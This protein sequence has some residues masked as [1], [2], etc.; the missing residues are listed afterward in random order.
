MEL[1][2]SLISSSYSF[3]FLATNPSA[4]AHPISFCIT[5]NQRE[6][7]DGNET[8][9]DYKRNQFY[10]SGCFWAFFFYVERTPPL[11]MLETFMVSNPQSFSSDY[12]NEDENK[13]DSCL[14]VCGTYLNSFSSLRNIWEHDL[15]HDKDPNRL[16]IGEPGLWAHLYLQQVQKSW[17]FVYFKRL[18]NQ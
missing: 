12:Q 2:L 1:L 4:V 15:N 13:I 14:F 17:V 3:F 7:E 10:F 9:I 11:G 5:K 6:G 18:K 16:D 8:I